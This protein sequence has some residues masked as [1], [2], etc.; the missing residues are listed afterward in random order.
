MTRSTA[1]AVHV[2]LPPT[3]SVRPCAGPHEDTPHEAMS[4]RRS[5]R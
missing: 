3:A 5:C 4:C 1:P 2:S